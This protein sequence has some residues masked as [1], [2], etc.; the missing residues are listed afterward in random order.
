M[1]LLYVSSLAFALTVS[2]EGDCQANPLYATTVERIPLKNPRWGTN[3]KYYNL[4]PFDL[5]PEYA[6]DGKW[7]KAVSNDPNSGYTHSLNVQN[8]NNVFEADITGCLRTDKMYHVNVYPDPRQGNTRN[9]Y[10]GL[11]V[12]LDSPY[13]DCRLCF[14]G[15]LNDA[16]YSRGR[17]YFLDHGMSFCCRSPGPFRDRY[18]PDAKIQL[19]FGDIDGSFA[20]VELFQ[21]KIDT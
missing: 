4:G 3:G 20:E 18:V 10:S 17:D 11:T 2:S 8:H 14:P 19:D 5:K 16:L 7:G 6:I 15:P 12:R 1:K 21:V 13:F 9:Y